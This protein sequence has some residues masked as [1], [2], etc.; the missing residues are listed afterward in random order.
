M[1]SLTFNTS[2]FIIGK[3]KRSLT[4][5]VDLLRMTTDDQSKISFVSSISSP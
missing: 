5:L 1:I 2:F 3:L 4:I